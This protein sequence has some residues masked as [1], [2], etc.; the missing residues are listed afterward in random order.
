MNLIK[1][2][3]MNNKPIVLCLLLFIAVLTTLFGTEQFELK[4]GTHLIGKERVYSDGDIQS[5]PE[6]SFSTDIRNRIVAHNTEYLTEI[7]WVM[8]PLPDDYRNLENLA[9]C[10]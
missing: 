10:F 7:T 6:F 9:S 8:P 2:A 5:L 1:R 3:K 4:E